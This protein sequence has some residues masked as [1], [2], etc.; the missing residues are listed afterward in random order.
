LYV[1]NNVQ[2][3]DGRVFISVKHDVVN[4]ASA[5][6]AGFK[7]TAAAVTS[8]TASYDDSLIFLRSAGT[9]NDTVHSAP[10]AI[11]FYVDNH[12][13][14]AGSGANYNDLGDLALTIAENKNA[15]FAGDATISGGLTVSTDFEAAAAVNFSALANAGSDVDKFLV[16]DSGDVKFRTGAEVLSDIGGITDVGGKITKKIS[17]DGSAT[18]FT[19]AHSFGTPHVMT[20][21]LDYGN[22]GTGAT[23]EVVQ[24]TVKR[25]SDNAIDIVFGVAPTTSEDYLV[26]I[27]KMPAIS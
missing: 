11:K 22:N 4:T 24:T 17:G 14:N 25:N 8:G 3:V 16:S 12:A 13:T 26:L 18:T 21:L 19:V 9:A 27:T 5:V 1:S 7:M 23:Y 2:S 6:G 10:K 20:Q 15:T